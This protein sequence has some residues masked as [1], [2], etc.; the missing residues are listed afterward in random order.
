[1]D[2]QTTKTSKL[3]YFGQTPNNPVRDL[4]RITAFQHSSLAVNFSCTT[5]RNQCSN[6]NRWILSTS[7]KGNHSLSG[8]LENKQYVFMGISI[9]FRDALS[10]QHGHANEV[11][12]GNERQT[13]LRTT[14]IPC[15]KGVWNDSSA[16]IV[17]LD[18]TSSSTMCNLHIDTITRRK[19]S[20]PISWL[21]NISL[22]SL[23]AKDEKKIVSL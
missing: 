4:S 15:G 20:C 14:L 16:R 3:Q 2:F 19:P 12:L 23:N 7:I 6:G 11:T 22:I 13:E 5:V 1:M 10:V 17:S 18:T 8:C 21:S 9:S